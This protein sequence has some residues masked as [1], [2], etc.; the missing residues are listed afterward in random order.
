[1]YKKER[2]EKRDRKIKSTQCL[3]KCFHM[4]FYILYI[5]VTSHECYT[6]FTFYMYM[7]YLARITTTK[8]TRSN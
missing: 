1:M 7:F 6:V 4:K 8:R 3:F 2:E 5:L